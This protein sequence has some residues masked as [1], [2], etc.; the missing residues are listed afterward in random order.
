MYVHT[1]PPMTMMMMIATP[2]F[3]KTFFSDQH[4]KNQENKKWYM[5]TYMMANDKICSAK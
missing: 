1:E 3:K 5:K 2:A 4:V